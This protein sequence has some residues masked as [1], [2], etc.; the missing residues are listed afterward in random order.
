MPPLLEP[1]SPLLLP[2][3]VL[4]APVLVPGPV[5]SDEVVPGPGPVLVLSTAP[6]LCEPVLA[7]GGV[8][9]VLSLLVLV[10]VGAAA[11]LPLL[12]SLEGAGSELGHPT[13][14]RHASRQERE[15]QERM[16]STVPTA[17]PRGD[18][19]Q[20][21]HV[22]TPGVSGQSADRRCIH[23]RRANVHAGA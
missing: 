21:R 9:P 10:V 17:A 15:D 19:R 7:G 2:S 23:R 22:R 6:L 8:V 16:A 13:K 18:A 3:P 11:V 14:P 20:R 12:L 5:V 4:A 1:A